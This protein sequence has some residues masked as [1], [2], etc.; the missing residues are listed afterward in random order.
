MMAE[1]KTYEA[2][3]NIIKYRMLVILRENGGEM[4]FEAFANEHVKRGWAESSFAESFEQFAPD[5]IIRI[6]NPLEQLQ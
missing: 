4:T 2:N 6:T 1:A 5:D 3:P